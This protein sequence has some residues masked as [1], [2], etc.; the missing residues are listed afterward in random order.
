MWQVSTPLPVV[1]TSIGMREV[2]SSGLCKHPFLP[3][4]AVPMAF[5]P[6]P[7]LRWQDELSQSYLSHLVWSSLLPQGLNALKALV[8]N[9]PDPNLQI[10][11]SFIS[12][13]SYQP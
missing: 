11:K 8:P 4:P 7:A 13:I 9:V 2:E 5:S 3:S 10:V 6:L 12:Y 1:S